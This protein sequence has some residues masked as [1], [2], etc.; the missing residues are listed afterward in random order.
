M[1]IWRMRIACWIPKAASTQYVILIALPLH[2]G[3]PNAAP[4]YV[5]LHCLPFFIFDT[6]YPSMYALN[7]P[8]GYLQTA[9]LY[10]RVTKG[11][12]GDRIP[13]GARFSAPV[14]TGP[15]THPASCKMSAGSFP[16]VK[17]GRDVT[18][19]PH[20]FLVPRSKTEYSYT[21]TLPKGLR[22]L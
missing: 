8:Q 17:S 7:L 10:L 13:V 19:T 20:P 12:T 9:S 16:G 11:L 5:T 2:N 18:L 21:S 22:G 6:L 3:C 15:G 1:T 4:C 14:Q